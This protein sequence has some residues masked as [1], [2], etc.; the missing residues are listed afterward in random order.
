MS[1]R[2]QRSACKHCETQLAPDVVASPGIPARDV[3]SRADGTAFLRKRWFK[4]RLRTSGGCGQQ[5]RGNSERYPQSLL[6]MPPYVIYARKS[7]DWKTGQV[8]S[9]ESQVKELQLPPRGRT[10]RSWKF[11]P[12]PAP[13]STR[14]AGF[15]EMMTTHP[16][17]PDTR[18]LVLEDGP[19]A[20]NHLDHGAIPG[21]SLTNC[22][23]KSSPPIGPTPRRH[24]SV[25][26]EL[27]TRDGDEVLDDLSVAERQARH[28]GTP[29]ARL[30]NH[31]PRLGCHP[32]DP[33]KRS[34]RILSA[35]SS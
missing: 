28:P 29:G 9:I 14:G 11:S 31:T 1:M 10:S 7:T 27:R 4:L 32:M 34:S 35:L 12:N 19:T 6:P 13:Q 2:V 8:V 18:H 15:G 3:V 5:F 20:R 17:R 26:W 21:T 25:H 23:S 22:W 16:P 33:V 24:R 30:V